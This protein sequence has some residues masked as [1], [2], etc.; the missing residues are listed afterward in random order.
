MNTVPRID[1]RLLVVMDRLQMDRLMDTQMDTQTDRYKTVL[2]NGL[3][4][5]VEMGDGV[6]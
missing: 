4:Q 3:M 1:Q 5:V 2:P 6:E